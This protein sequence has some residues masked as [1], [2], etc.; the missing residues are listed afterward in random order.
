MILWLITTDKQLFSEF[1]QLRTS[2]FNTESINKNLFI[3]NNLSI[4]DINL[5]TNLALYSLLARINLLEL[6]L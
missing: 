5:L 2:F 6:T 1:R 4:Q 3:I